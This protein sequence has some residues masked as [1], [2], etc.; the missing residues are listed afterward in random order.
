MVRH[1]ANGILLGLFGGGSDGGGG[2]GGGG[3]GG[4][5]GGELIMI[6]ADFEVP[7]RCMLMVNLRWWWRWRWRWWWR[8]RRRMMLEVLI[9]ASRMTVTESIPLFKR[10]LLLLLPLL[11]LD[12]VVV[13]SDLDFHETRVNSLPRGHD[14]AYPLLAL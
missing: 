8:R 2:G 9:S 12:H 11:T 13:Q 6:D 7:Y 5:D 3:C 14:N 4:G 10:L 1:N